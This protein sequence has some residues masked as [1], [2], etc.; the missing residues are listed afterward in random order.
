MFQFLGE[1]PSFVQ[2]LTDIEVEVSGTMELEVQ[3]RGEPKPKVT[4]Y[5]DGKEITDLRVR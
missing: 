3:V 5:Q 4:W 2:T 1:K